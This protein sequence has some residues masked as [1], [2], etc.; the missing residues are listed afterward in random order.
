MAI[1]SGRCD[2]QLSFSLIHVEHDPLYIMAESA[3]ALVPRV[4]TIVSSYLITEPLF[5]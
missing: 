4:R 3:N 2:L 1:F 5:D